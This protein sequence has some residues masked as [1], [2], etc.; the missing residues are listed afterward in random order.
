M[1][2]HNIVGPIVAA[3]N[4]WVVASVQPS[5]GATTNPDGSRQPVYGQ[6]VD[7]LVQ[8]QSLQY[9]D[10]MQLSGLNIQGEQRALYVSGDW[11]SIVRQDSKARAAT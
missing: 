3:V 10:L 5:A 9:K 4:P 7:I 6:A 2:L 8:M 11:Q 1:N